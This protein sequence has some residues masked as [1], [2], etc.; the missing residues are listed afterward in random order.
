MNNYE[1]DRF[2]THLNNHDAIAALSG[3]RDGLNREQRK[4]NFREIKRL[5]GLAKF[6]YIRVKG[7][8]REED[9][10]VDDESSVIIFA[11]KEREKELRDLAVSMGKRFEQSSI[12]FIDTKGDAQYISTRSDSWVGEIGTVRKLG[13]YKAL[14]PQ[15]MVDFYTRIR[16]RKFVFKAFEE[17]VRYN[18][19]IREK[20][21]SKWFCDSLKKYGENVIE[22]W[23]KN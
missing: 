4:R 23:F 18:P 13:K 5:L 12:L 20:Q 16:G 15:E 1:N 8:Y 3:D 17:S 22:E 19:D 9:A 11:P 10:Y 14:K 2:E 6:G 7:G 21:L